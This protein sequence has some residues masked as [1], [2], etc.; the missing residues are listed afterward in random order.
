MELS[1]LRPDSTPFLTEET[2]ASSSLRSSLDNDYYQSQ[3]CDIHI[4]DDRPSEQTI[5]P[6]GSNRDIDAATWHGG[7]GNREGLVQHLRVAYLRTK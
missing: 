3:G 7:L 6:T 4:Y 2:S 5:L 1:S